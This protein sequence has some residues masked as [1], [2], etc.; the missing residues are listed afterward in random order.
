V[1]PAQAAQDYGDLAEA[2]PDRAAGN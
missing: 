2:D 1:T